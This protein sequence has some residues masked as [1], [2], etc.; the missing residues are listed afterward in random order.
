MRIVN[1]S[2]SGEG[3]VT[4]V[5]VDAAVV[6]LSR[7]I[8]E[9][10]VIRR[11]VG[12][13]SVA[14]LTPTI[15]SGVRAVATSPTSLQRKRS[16]AVLHQPQASA[17][18]REAISHAAADLLGHLPSGFAFTVRPAL[19]HNGVGCLQWRQGCQG[20]RPPSRE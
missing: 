12:S 6:R 16:D 14:H 20:T 7:S 9:A 17:Q 4:L 5:L 19:R 11:D 8:H 3:S 1:S 13:C 10:T 15:V 2:V 18:G